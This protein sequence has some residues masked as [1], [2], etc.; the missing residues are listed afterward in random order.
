[1]GQSYRPPHLGWFIMPK[2]INFAGPLIPEWLTQE[3]AALEELLVLN[4]VNKCFLL[5]SWSILRHSHVRPLPC[6][7]LR[8]ESEPVGFINTAV[9]WMVPCKPKASRGWLSSHNGSGFHESWSRILRE[10]AAQINLRQVA[11]VWKRCYLGHSGTPC[12]RSP[13]YEY[14]G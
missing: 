9:S 14:H 12:N 8:Q 10:A 11:K 2:M 4:C 13:Q 6:W 7:I 5:V 1:M 3:I